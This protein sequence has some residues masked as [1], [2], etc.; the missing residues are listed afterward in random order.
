VLQVKVN[1]E[2]GFKVIFRSK[3]DLENYT[4]NKALNPIFNLFFNQ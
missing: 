3:H 4:F 2:D 1:D